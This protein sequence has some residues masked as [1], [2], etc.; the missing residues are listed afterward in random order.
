MGVIPLI[1]EGPNRNIVENRQ[2]FEA[3]GGV[4]GEVILIQGLD[5]DQLLSPNNTN[6]SYD[7]R[8]GGEYRDHRDVSGKPLSEDGVIKLLPGAAVIVE[9]EEFIH[10]PISAFGHVVPRVSLLQ[11]GISNTSL[12][13]DPGY[14]GRLLITVFNLGKKTIQLRRGEP[15]CALYVLQVLEGARPYDKPPKRI[16]GEAGGRVWQ[17]LRDLLEAN[18]ALVMVVLIIVTIILVIVQIIG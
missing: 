12:K 9:T 6:V 7:L 8:V 17:R 11:K 16:V 3:A 1:I 10:F 14:N 5:R 4:R 18:S 15:F 13:V 2:E